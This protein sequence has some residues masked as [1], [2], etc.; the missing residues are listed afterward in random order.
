MWPQ[1]S[2]VSLRVARGFSGFLSSRYQVLGPHLELRPQPQG[3]YKL[4]TW[5]SR[6]LWS[7][8]RGVRPH[9]QW[10]LASLL[11]SPA[12]TVVLGFLASCHS[13]LQLSLKVPQGCHT[14]HRVLSWYSGWQSSQCRGIW[15]ISSWFGLRCLFELWHDAGSLYMRFH[16]WQGH[17]E[18]LDSA[19]QIKSQEVLCLSIS[20][21]T[22]IYLFY[23]FMSLTNTS[24]INGGLSPNTFL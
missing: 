15:L 4:L 3:S 22:R 10:R 2:P 16:S 12:V 19:S 14:C 21:K 13:D 24:D 20:P 17:A 18:D 9:L 7:F 6:F 5:I 1:E 8:H 11:S 23:Y